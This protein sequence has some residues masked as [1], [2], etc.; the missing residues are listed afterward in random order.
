M[1]LRSKW[2]PVV[3]EAPDGMSASSLASS[4]PKMYGAAVWPAAAKK[5][6]TLPTSEMSQKSSMT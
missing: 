3:L 1:N 2:L 6:V 4:L 5:L